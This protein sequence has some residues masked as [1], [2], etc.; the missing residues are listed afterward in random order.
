MSRTRG[1]IM[2][3]Y[4]HR[5]SISYIISESNESGTNTDTWLAWVNENHLSAQIRDRD[6]ANTTNGRILAHGN[7]PILS[8]ARLIV[9]AII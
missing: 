1:R 6:K 8:H 3:K 5:N 7:E 2:M 4:D 9:A